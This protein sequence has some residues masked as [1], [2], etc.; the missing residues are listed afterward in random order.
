MSDQG[1]TSQDDQ[2]GEDG[3]IFCQNCHPTTR[4]IGY[5]LQFFAGIVAFGF[6][7]IFLFLLSVTFLI[8]GSLLIILSPLW[9]KSP[10]RCFLDLKDPGRLIS[11]IIFL[12]FLGATVFVSTQEGDIFYLLKIVFGACL[13]VSGIWYFLSFFQNG[14]TALVVCI[15]TCCGKNENSQVENTE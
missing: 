13:A 8:V 12:V 5:Y 9:I 1:Y 10:K 11:F 2:Q 14:Q 7:I 6:G 3:G 15:K 4:K